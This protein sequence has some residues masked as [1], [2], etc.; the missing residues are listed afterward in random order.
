MIKLKILLQFKYL[1][2][3]LSFILSISIIIKLNTK[4]NNSNHFILRIES[5]NY[6][7]NNYTLNLSNKYISYYKGDYDFHLGDYVEINGKLIKPNNNTIPNLFNYK[8]YL[9]YKGIDYN[10]EINDIKLYK[11][12]NLIYE[13]K[14]RIRRIIDSRKSKAY[15]YAFIL[16]DTSY[17]DK[18]TKLSFNKMGISHLFAISGTHIAFIS[19]LIN[20]LYKKK[21]LNIYLYFVL[22]NLIVIIYYFLTNHLVSLLRILLF[23]NLSFIN[24]QTV[25]ETEAG[26]LRR[27]IKRLGVPHI[28]VSMPANETEYAAIYSAYINSSS[29]TIKYYN[30]GTGLAE[31][32]TGFIENFEGELI[33]DNGTTPNWNISF[34]ITSM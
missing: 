19:F 15:L 12:R 10:L 26:T 6:E 9:K 18:D 25:N 4:E 32:F 13:L 24:K 20:Y 22:V 14:D 21:G 31:T 16:G 30:P 3:I 17:I 33:D 1:I 23:F 5:I 2:I 34:E 27:Y 29:H 7:N 28:T 8:D 11:K